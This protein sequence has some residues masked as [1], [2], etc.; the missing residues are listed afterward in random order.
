MPVSKG[1]DTRMN[2]KQAL[3]AA[4]TD[5]E[6]IAGQ[7]RP[8]NTQ[9]W[10]LDTHSNLPEQAKAALHLAIRIEQNV[11]HYRAALNA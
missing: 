6:G 8:A 5:L 7:L 9:A 4:I 10:M 3:Q 11:A 1:M 2:T